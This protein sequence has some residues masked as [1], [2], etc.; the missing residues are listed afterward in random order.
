MNPSALGSAARFVSALGAVVAGLRV[1]LLTD[2]SLHPNTALER[3]A[4]E[5]VRSKGLLCQSLSILRRHK[6]VSPRR[7]Q[8]TKRLNPILRALRGEFFLTSGLASQ[9]ASVRA[10]RN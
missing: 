7:S 3:A 9:P 1:R 5:R 8:R 4:Y 2:V 10:S 6:F